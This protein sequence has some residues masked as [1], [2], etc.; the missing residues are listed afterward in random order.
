MNRLEYNEEQGCVETKRDALR[1]VWIGALAFFVLAASTG[2]FYRFAIAYGQ[3]LGFDLV[4]VR[5]AHSHVMYFGWVTPL[6]FALIGGVTVR[7]RSEK[8]L[9]ARRDR[10]PWILVCCFL[11]AAV[12]YPL[13]MMFGY[14]PVPIGDARIPIA[15]VGS[16][17]NMAAWYGFVVWYARRIRSLPRTHARALADSSVIFLVLATLGALGLSLLKP[18]GIDSD[19]ISVGL[20]HVFLDLFSEGWFVLGLLSVAHHMVLP[21]YSVRAH[22]SIYPLVLGIP[23]TFALGMPSLLVPPALEVV[24]R[25]G[26]ILVGVGLLAN[27]GLLW[28][29]TGTDEKKMWRLPLVLL[30]L[31]A[32]AQT[33]G[34]LAPGIWMSDVHGLRILYLHLMLLGFVSLGLIAAATQRWRPESRSARRAMYAA[35]LFVLV[36]LVPLSPLWPAAFVGRWSFVLAA[37]ASLGPV[38]VAVLMLGLARSNRVNAVTS[39]V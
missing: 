9:Y 15:V 1:W 39:A 4:N 22:W 23:L 6:L 10:L 29:A 38:M 26:G 2:A 14:R 24:A 30:T 25:V 16:T 21:N 19:A 32:A 31:K 27:V 17:L 28:T 36:T 3:T 33:I 5:H 12:A 11:A 37:W 34:S 8:G 20:T 7:L 18:L 35:V 13:F